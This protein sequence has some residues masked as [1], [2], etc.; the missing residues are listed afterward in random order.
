[1]NYA[2]KTAPDSLGVRIGRAAWPLDRGRAAEAQADADA[3]PRIDPRSRD[4]RRLLGLAPQARK[5]LT[6]AEPI[7]AALA[8][9]APGAAW[10]RSQWARVLA[11]SRARQNPNDPDA[12]A[13]LRTV[14]YRRD[15]LDEAEKRL[16]A[17]LDS[18]HGSSDTA[19]ILTLIEG[20]RGHPEGARVLLQAALA[21]PG[22]FFFRDEARQWLDRLAGAS[23]SGS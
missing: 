4:A 2:V 6:R 19:Y 10:L 11:E 3:A 20:D 13:T 23:K 12:V 17:V 18:G 21:A 15:R 9:E 1:M 22:L 16:Q 8:Q 14:Y 5:D 7:F